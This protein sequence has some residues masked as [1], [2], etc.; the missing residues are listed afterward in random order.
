MMGNIP[1]QENDENE[2]FAEG[3]YKRNGNNI[4]K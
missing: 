2:A 3:D 4:V 1:L